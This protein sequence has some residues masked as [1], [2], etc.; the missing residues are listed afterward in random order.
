MLLARRNLFHDKIRLTATLTGIVFAIFLITVQV[1]LFI[2]FCVTTSNVVDNAGADI[3]I[4]AKDVEAFDLGAAFSER[5]YYQIISTPGVA[6]AAKLLVSFTRW[7][8][9]DGGEESIL[10]IGFE[11]DKHLGAPWAIAQGQVSDVKLADSVFIDEFYQD[12]LKVSKL[13]QIVEIN[14]RRAQVVGFTRGIRSFTTSPFIFTSFKNSLKYVPDI[15]QDQTVYV[16][17]KA[18]ANVAP[19]VLKE[20]LA[21]RLP[22]NDIYLAAEFAQKTQV[23]WM[24]TTGAGIGILLA[25]AMGLVV[26]VVVVTQ[27]IYATTIDHIREFGT[28]KAMGAT[29]RYIYRIIIE[30]AIISALIGYGFG[31]TISYFLIQFTATS[32]AAILLNWQLAVAMF[33]LTLGMCILAAVV[34]INK[35]TKIDPAMVF[36]G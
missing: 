8:Q 26:G 34:S 25:A 5:K 30:Q 29:N 16:L 20:R 3:W 7:K 21:A 33:F 23:Y 13:G 14:Q 4:T 6:E 32:G 24:F 28:L 27:T 36:K 12:K 10:I 17:V 22:Q 15:R 9:P 35:V 1:G 11:P 18:A 2:G 31:I 19:S